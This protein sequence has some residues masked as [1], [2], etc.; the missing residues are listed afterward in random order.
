[1]DIYSELLSYSESTNNFSWRGTAEELKSLI[2]LMIKGKDCE[3]SEENGEFIEDTIHNAVSY[4]LTDVSFRLYSTKTLMLFGNKASLVR[5]KFHE[6]LGTFETDES[7]IHD[8]LK[9]DGSVSRPDPATNLDWTGLKGDLD[10]I[11]ED[12]ASIKAQI[13]PISFQEKEIDAENAELKKK[14][15][16]LENENKRLVEEVFHYKTNLKK[17]EDEK[18]SLLTALNI[19]IKESNLGT[20]SLET[21]SIDRRSHTLIDHDVDTPKDANQEEDGV[22]KN[23][24]DVK[25][26]RR[27]KGNKNISKTNNNTDNPPSFSSQGQAQA[28]QNGTGN[29]FSRSSTVIA[30]DS[31]INNIMGWRM[32][33]NTERVSVKSF[34]GATVE[35]M[36]YHIKPTLSHSPDN[37]ILHVGT[38]NLKKENPDD[39][40]KK[41]EDLCNIIRKDCPKTKI[42]LSEI[43]PRSDFKDAKTAREQVNNKLQSLCNS[44]NFSFISHP[45]ILDDSLNGR[46]VHLNRKGTALLSKDFK[47]YIYKD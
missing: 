4:K 20:T 9:D 18:Q 5:D 14:I 32:S 43:T 46:G 35:D 41:I 12:I 27:K 25:E 39:I 21:A 23:T 8:S 3:S 15:C 11:K 7:N 22:T 30:G 31:I 44:Q 2:W 19:V 42:A 16:K 24:D 37:I 17:I 40:C 33:N 10:L 45:T 6:L 47:N 1:M 29:T 38:N 13:R 28:T 34:S 26:K 36:F